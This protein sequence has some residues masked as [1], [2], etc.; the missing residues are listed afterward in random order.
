M[1]QVKLY[2]RTS[3]DN[4]RQ[5]RT[6]SHGLQLHLMRSARKRMERRIPDVA[7]PWLAGTFDKD[8][9]VSSAATECLSVFLDTDE[10]VTRFWRRLQ[11][12]VLDYALESV[13]ET[14]DTLSDE[15][16][17]TKEDAEA[18][19]YRVVGAA[20]A[21]VLNL[22]QKVGV[23]QAQYQLD[24]FLGT[25]SVWALAAA[26]DSHVRRMVYQLAQACL[27]KHPELLT[28]HVPSLG[29]AI[30][31]DALKT[32]QTGSALDLVRVLTTL[33][34]LHP[35][36]WGTKKQPFSRLQSFVERG[37][38]GSSSAFWQEL[39]QLI[40]ALSTD[41][42][43]SDVAHGFLKALR[44]GISSREEHRANAA[45]AWACYFETFLMFLAKLTPQEA[46]LDFIKDT[47]YPVTEQYLYPV[48]E[49]TSWATAAPLSLLPKAWATVASSTSEEIRLSVDQEWARLAEVLVT[50][51]SN[52]LPEVS[53]DF[54]SSQQLVADEGDKWFSL[55][56]A[57][58]GYITANYADEEVSKC[59]KE[60]F[61]QASRQVLQGAVELLTRRNFK[62]FGA[63]S[64]IKSALEHCPGLLDDDGSYLVDNIFPTK[65]PDDLKNLLGSSS[66][67]Y[68]LS[69]LNTLGVM[70]NHSGRY[71]G[72]WTSVVDWLLASDE[73]Y[74]A[75]RIA[76]L[77]TPKEAK[78]LAQSHSALQEFLVSSSLEITPEADA[79]W[80]VFEAA[81]NH[82]AFA[83]SSLQRLTRDLIKA[84]GE[85]TESTA[86]ILKRLQLILQCKP[87]LFAGASELHVQLV[88]KLLALTEIS[89]EAVSTQATTIRD[90]LDKHTD[91]APSLVG[92]VRKNLDK[93][94][95]SSLE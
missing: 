90:M 94:G 58:T 1:P 65:R 39:R 23:D 71:D 61:Y 93:V 9:A 85:P 33:T 51:M 13:I 73:Q 92:I 40:A 38:Q 49:K 25:D 75:S 18:K 81:L 26:E 6:L 19:Y 53:K 59:L 20:L 70:W 74:V 89:G 63:A 3:I 69:C 46:K 84:I 10:K 56:G 36:V 16:S 30:V 48:A 28:S 37:S 4:S 64:L 95:Y 27:Q 22:L 55:V 54:Q 15:R 77:I 79:S 35:E 44:T 52:S 12:Q 32:R 17:T 57:I 21:L 88:A 80:E 45:Y 67:P 31:S 87:S 7:G 82:D 47:F 5:A 62:P 2:G 91:A 8:K 14:P 60:R 24:R 72:I 76:V 66:A 42:I 34:K 43:S 11:T 50:R 68:I 86:A 29:R 83:E 41:T 78:D